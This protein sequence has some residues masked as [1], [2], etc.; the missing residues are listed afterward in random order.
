[1]PAAKDCWHGIEKFPTKP[2]R[3]LDERKGHYRYTEER[4]HEGDRLYV[5]GELHTPASR[6]SSITV[7]D[8]FNDRLNRWKHNQPRLLRRFDA[9]GDGRIDSAEW[10]I[11]RETARTEVTTRLQA[12]ARDTGTALDIVRKPNDGQPFILAAKAQV[13]LAGKYRYYAR[14]NLILFACCGAFALYL[15]YTFFVKH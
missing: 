8:A 12:H 11:A 15:S 4:M 9:N 2:M 10:E 13:A 5:S 1:M 6:H 3:V 14:N 7:E